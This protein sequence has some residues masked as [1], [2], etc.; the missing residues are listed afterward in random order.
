MEAVEIVKTDGKRQLA[1][2]TKDG[3]VIRQS[4]PTV[5]RL[6]ESANH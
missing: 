5:R 1:G 3:A 6:V 4:G 2:I